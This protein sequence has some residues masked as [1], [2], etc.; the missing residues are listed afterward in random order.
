MP[1]AAGIFLRSASNN[2]ISPKPTVLGSGV[3]GIVV[4]NFNFGTFNASTNPNGIQGLTNTDAITAAVVGQSLS[5]SNARNTIT[6]FIVIDSVRVVPSAALT[7]GTANNFS[8]RLNRRAGSTLSPVILGTITE[9]SLTI[10]ALTGPVDLGVFAEAGDSIVLV[11][12]GAVDGTAVPGTNIN[13][14]VT[15]AR[16]T[17][18]GRLVAARAV[19]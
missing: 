16:L 9:A 19:A 5:E 1:T 4:S 2:N 3:Q 15:F 11:P 14:Q 8:V 17:N 6:G 12:D 10:N 13:V 18:G 7:L